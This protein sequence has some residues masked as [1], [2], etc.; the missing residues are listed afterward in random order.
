MWWALQLFIILVLRD[1]AGGLAAARL[2]KTRAFGGEQ[3]EAGIYPTRLLSL[4]VTIF[5]EILKTKMSL[6]I[7]WNDVLRHL[8]S[9]EV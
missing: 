9:E 2:R 1:G 6:E 3:G 5:D 4:Q 7:S 8:Q